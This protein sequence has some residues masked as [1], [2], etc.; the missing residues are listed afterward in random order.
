MKKLL[1]LS[2]LGSLVLSG[3]LF[4]A[5][6][7][8]QSNK[9]LLSLSG[10][11]SPKDMPKYRL[12]IAK[13]IENMSVKEAREF[14]ESL[15]EQAQKVYDSMKVKEFRAYKHEVHKEMERF[16]R[17]NKEECKLLHPP[18][19]IHDEHNGPKPP[20]PPKK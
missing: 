1:T 8:K 17:D 14:E 9:D 11:V 16:C 20:K 7:E 12:E 19:P 2:V 6:F 15:R 3:V 13:R 4:G 18:K 10:K 5:D